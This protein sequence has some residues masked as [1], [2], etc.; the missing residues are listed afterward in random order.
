MTVF[1]PPR[2]GLHERAQKE[3]ALL[4][5]EGYILLDIVAPIDSDMFGRLQKRGALRSVGTRVSVWRGG[6]VSEHWVKEK[7]LRAEAI[8]RLVVA[9]EDPE[10]NGRRE[11]AKKCSREILDWLDKLGRSELNSLDDQAKT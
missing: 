5:A 6:L 8:A 4:R 10:Y 1:G 7:V 3:K 9:D 11:F 2:G